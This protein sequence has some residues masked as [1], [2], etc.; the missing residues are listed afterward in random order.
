MVLGISHHTPLH[1]SMAFTKEVPSSMNIGAGDPTRPIPPSLDVLVD[2]YFSYI[3]CSIFCSFID[4]VY[5]LF[6]S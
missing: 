2:N 4:F 3:L 5:S 6:V 1:H